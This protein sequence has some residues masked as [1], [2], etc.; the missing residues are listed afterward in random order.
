[1]QCVHAPI[2]DNRIVSLTKLSSLVIFATEALFQP[3]SW[4]TA[5]ISSRKGC[6][7]SG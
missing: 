7:Y 4:I 1:M 3:R 6:T 2:G 5:S